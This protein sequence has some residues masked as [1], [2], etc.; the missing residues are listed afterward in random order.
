MKK[1][2]YNFNVCIECQKKNTDVPCSK[3]CK[4][5]KEMKEKKKWKYIDV[6]IVGMKAQKKL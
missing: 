3:D 1:R 5:L 4:Y 6:N 2:K